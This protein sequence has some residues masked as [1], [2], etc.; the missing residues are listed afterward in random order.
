MSKTKEYYHE[1]ICANYED[2]IARKLEELHFL[3]E[4]FENW[5][6]AQQKAQKERQWALTTMHKMSRRESNELEEFL[7]NRRSKKK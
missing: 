7:A 6:K 5:K 4:S 1:E 2:S 3:E